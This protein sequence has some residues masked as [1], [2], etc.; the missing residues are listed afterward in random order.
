[1]CL[2]YFGPLGPH[3]APVLNP[4]VF[5]VLTPKISKIWGSVF[6]DLSFLGGLFL[7]R[8]WASFFVLFGRLLGSLG[9]PWGLCGPPWVPLGRPWGRLGPPWV[10]FWAP[11]GSL[12]SLF[13]ILWAAFGVES[14]P[15][16]V[17]FAP[18]GLPRSIFEHFLHIFSLGKLR[19]A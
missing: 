10:P 12:G 15:I 13:G 3:R 4:S 17:H 8:F 16:C 9:P 11:L 18:G 2:C 6:Q 19:E 5:H 1:M 7:E 14:G